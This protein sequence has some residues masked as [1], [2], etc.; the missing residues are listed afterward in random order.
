MIKL[1]GFPLSGNAHRVRLMLSLLNLDYQ[2]IHV[3]LDEAEHKQE[4]FT[5]INP[6]QLI[7]VLDDDGFVVRDSV[8]ILCYL[9]T[10]YAPK[11]YPTDA[12]SIARIQEWLAFST[13]DLSVGPAAAR[14]VNVFGADLDH[15]KIIEQSHELLKKVDQHLNGREWLALDQVSIA[16]VAAYTYIAHAPEGDVDLSSYK[17]IQR[18]LKMVEALPN[19]VAM[20]KTP[21]GLAG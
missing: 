10:Q 6:L 2:L 16:D 19:F 17:H 18:W 20:D 15:K 7:P 9:A 13:K 8:A 3:K 21:V 4:K 11:W 14:L 1:Y 12:Q 5:A